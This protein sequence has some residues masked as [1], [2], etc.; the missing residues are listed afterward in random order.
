MAI[1]VAVVQYQQNKSLSERMIHIEEAR[2]LDEIRKDKGADIAAQIIFDETEGTDW[3]EIRN[4]GPGGAKQIRVEPIDDQFASAEGL[5][6]VPI[7]EPAGRHLFRFHV[8]EHP[9]R[10]T[11]VRITWIDPSGAR[12]EIVTTGFIR[13]NPLQRRSFFTRLRRYSR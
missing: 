9:P 6:V 5:D 12:D 3:L 1:V 4:R 7:L 8:Y 2:R 11:D 10:A 13:Q